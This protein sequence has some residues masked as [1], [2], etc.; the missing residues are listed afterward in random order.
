MTGK[1]LISQLIVFLNEYL[2]FNDETVLEKVILDEDLVSALMTLNTLGPSSNFSIFINSLINIVN[3]NNEDFLSNNYG[4]NGQIEQI[5]FTIVELQGKKRSFYYSDTDFGFFST[6]I[7]FNSGVL[8]DLSTTENQLLWKQIEEFIE[9]CY[10]MPDLSLLNIFFDAINGLNLNL[11]FILN[12]QSIA[13][14]HER[15]FSYIYLSFLNSS[16]SLILKQDLKYTIPQIN[17]TLHL[18]NTKNYEQFFDIYDV[19]NEINMSPDILT[20]FLKLYHTLEYLVYRVYLVDLSNR[21]GANK[22]FVREFAISA[23]RMKVREGDTF[24]DNFKKIFISD[25]PQI[26]LDLTPVTSIPVK[27]FLRDKNIVRGFDHT[28][29]DRIAR[30]IYGLRC[31]IVHNKESEYHLTIATSEDYQIIIPLISEVIRSMEFLVIQ[32]IADNDL[33][34]NYP[35]REMR[36]F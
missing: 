19:I 23:E 13:L 16:N 9:R 10:S 11:G 2:G 35:R 33:S 12:K 8:V 18:D 36:L 28:N 15:H 4:I 30:L 14:N 24:V 5:D 31:S 17:P 27:D 7:L 21:V 34:I 1:E 25:L 29:I 22:F 3:V 26:S 20:R 6:S 32:K